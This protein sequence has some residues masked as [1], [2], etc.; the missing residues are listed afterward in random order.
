MVFLKL[1]CICAI[2]SEPCSL[3]CASQAAIWIGLGNRDGQEETEFDKAV[4]R[5]A[6]IIL[7]QLSTL[8]PE[9]AKQKRLELEQMAVKASH[10]P[11][12]RETL[13][14]TA[15]SGDSYS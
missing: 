5:A 6:R 2:Q 12:E 14:A 15:N 8:P 1:I 10:A 7:D 3:L 11:K 4:E 13:R 9:T